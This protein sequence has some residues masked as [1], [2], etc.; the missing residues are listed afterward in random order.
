MR[1]IAAFSLFFVLVSLV[2]HAEPWILYK[3]ERLPDGRFRH[4]FTNT[5]INVHEYKLIID[6]SWKTDPSYNNVIQTVN[7][8]VIESLQEN[9]S[10]DREVEALMNKITS[11]NNNL[12]NN[13]LERKYQ[14]QEIEALNGTL[15]S[16]QGIQQPKIQY[17][18]ESKAQCVGFCASEQGTCIADCQ[19][20]GQCIG[21]CAA[22]HGRCVSRCN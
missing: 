7:N 12:S 19:G 3:K 4:T 5:K 20:N 9:D 2:V 10:P 8:P 11:I 13:L 17:S 15:Q 21:R 6:Y 16:L 18:A 1:K 14:L 22:A